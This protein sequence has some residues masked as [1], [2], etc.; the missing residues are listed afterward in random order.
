MEELIG[1][2]HQQ[3]GHCLKQD[4]V[5]DVTKE[6]NVT[7]RVNVNNDNAIFT[8]KHLHKIIFESVS[9]VMCKPSKRID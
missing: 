7:Q 4:A 3:R 8:A 5:G 2:E 1:E 9:C 6:N